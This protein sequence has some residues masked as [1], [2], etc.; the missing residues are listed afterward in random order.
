VLLCGNY[1]FYAYQRFTCTVCASHNYLSAF[2]TA[3]TGAQAIIHSLVIADI[4]DG[5]VGA[6][7]GRACVFEIVENLPERVVAP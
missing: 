1:Y 3:Q 5:C 6:E 7:V 4:V 2:I